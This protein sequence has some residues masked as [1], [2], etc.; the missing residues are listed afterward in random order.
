MKLNFAEV[1]LANI[2]P[3]NH[4]SF[5]PDSSDLLALAFSFCI[6]DTTN[7][8]AFPGQSRTLMNSGSAC[9][10]R[11]WLAHDGY[12]QPVALDEWK[13]TLAELGFTYDERTRNATGAGKS[14]DV[15]MRFQVGIFAWGAAS[16]TD[17]VFCCP[18]PI[19]L[20]RK[21]QRVS[22]WIVRVVALELLPQQAGDVD[23]LT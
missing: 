11:D 8:K 10:T 1:D 7:E 2:W 6:I 13:R 20:S 12:E 21:D 16:Q 22:V 17:V 18:S 14:V 15:A 4:P 5:A 9:L 19:A 23:A 3:L